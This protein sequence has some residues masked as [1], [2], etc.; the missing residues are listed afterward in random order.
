MTFSEGGERLGGRV[1]GGGGV[2]GT[3][4]LFVS[5]SAS[6]AE[7]MASLSGIRSEN[8]GLSLLGL[9]YN[10]IIIVI[11]ILV[12]NTQASYMSKM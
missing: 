5:L 12:L 8:R 7:N 2:G 9:I 3:L 1:E 10:N 4:P 11:V 6:G